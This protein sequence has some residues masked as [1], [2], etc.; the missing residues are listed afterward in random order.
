MDIAGNEKA[1]E[2]AKRAALEQLTG[3]PLTQ[4][5][6][7]SVQTTKINNNIN[8][9]A[10]KAWNSRKTNA[11]QHCYLNAT[12]IMKFIST[13]TIQLL[14]VRHERKARSLFHLLSLFTL[15]SMLSLFTI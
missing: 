6:L 8:T 5:K 1:D 3:E 15:C 2:E 7:K 9:T 12:A 10:K 14:I 4:F 11:R 13:I